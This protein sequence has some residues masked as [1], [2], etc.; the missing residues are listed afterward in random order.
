MYWQSRMA[1]GKHQSKLVVFDRALIEQFIESRREHPFTLKHP[2]DFG[3]ASPSRAIASQ[4]IEGA[5][6]CRRHQPCRW[7]FR[8]ATELPNLKSSAKGI[9]NYVLGLC[10]VADPE[11]ARHSRNHATILSPK[12]MIAGLHY[13]LSA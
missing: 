8:D 10:K 4:E 5:I 7:V 13:G 12:Q 9:L 6:L 2:A 1:A 3:L 11:K